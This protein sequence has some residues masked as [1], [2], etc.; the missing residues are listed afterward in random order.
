MALPFCGD[1][2]NRDPHNKA[3]HKWP[4]TIR[5]TLHLTTSSS[6]FL[7]KSKSL[8]CEEGKR[9]LDTAK[10]LWTKY[11]RIKGKL[12]RVFWVHHRGVGVKDEITSI[13]LGSCIGHCYQQIHNLDYDD[14]VTELVSLNEDRDIRE[15]ERELLTSASVAMASA[16]S[17]MT[18][19][20]WKAK[21]Q[22][23]LQHTQGCTHNKKSLLFFF[24]FLGGGGDLGSSGHTL[25]RPLSRTCLSSQITQYSLREWMRLRAYCR[26]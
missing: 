6:T 11:F 1:R 3:D 2:E 21:T 18:P 25:R 20:V 23:S 10:N 14:M 7:T 19:N 16:A 17:A 26:N 13:T 8:F 15:R 12:R 5:R 9:L 4:L 22:S 24:F